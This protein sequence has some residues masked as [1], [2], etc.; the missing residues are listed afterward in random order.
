M[1]LSLM[2]GFAEAGKRQA[3]L[4][5]GQP[6]LKTRRSELTAG[7]AAPMQEVLQS[8]DHLLFSGKQG[9]SLISSIESKL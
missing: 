9:R 1:V 8:T 7:G 4:R 2:F 3:I 6:C 5:R